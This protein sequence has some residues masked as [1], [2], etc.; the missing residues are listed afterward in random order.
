ME[1][2]GAVVAVTKR[3]T[4]SASSLEMPI[5]RVGA[6]TLAALALPGVMTTVTHA[7]NPPEEGIVTL[8]YQAYKDSQPGLDRIKVNAPS[9]YLS[10]PV[11]G[12]WSIEAS[13]V[14]DNISGATP[15]WHTNIS[16]ASQMADR[17]LAGDVKV[18]RYFDRA[19]VGL[20][21]AHSDENDYRS[22][23]FAIDG[24]FSS[25][26]NNT[27]WMGGIGITRDV[28]NPVNELVI[29]ERKNT[30]EFLLGVTQ[31]LSKNDLAQLVLTHTRGRG[32]YSDPYKLADERPRQRNQSIA[33]ARWNHFIEG[34]DTT[35]RG[36]YRYYRDTF[37]VR[38]H[39]AQLEWVVPV[40]ERFIV[41]PTARY[42][43]QRAASFY[44]DPIYDPIVGEPFPV[45]NPKFYSADPRLS[46]YGA[47]TF[48]GKF[49]WRISRQWSVDAKYETYEQRSAWRLGGSGSFGLAPFR[50]QFVQ[51]GVSWRF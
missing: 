45:G 16:G 14:Q 50:A 31:A 5:K 1:S 22:K 9:L 42:Y 19:A 41:T 21:V 40:S 38:A 6:I 26:D 33:L 4:L 34:N 20:R 10:A 44:F 29:D 32:Y 49:E 48:G 11:A 24:R 30:S 3:N 27:T 46:S 15:R 37:G 2:E 47:I 25:T 39:T 13:V 7:E 36:S 51:L 8:R 28:I 12:V 43:T 35:L 23:A 18:T 17:R